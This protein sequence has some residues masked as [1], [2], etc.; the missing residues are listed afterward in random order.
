M[1]LE[2]MIDEYRFTVRPLSAE[3]GG[4]Y[5]IEYPDLPGCVSDGDTAE[6]A[7]RNGRDAALSYLQSC[8]KHGDPV[9]M[10]AS[11]K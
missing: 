6:E 4:G 11:T 7:V 8:V 5:L 3:D 9:P 2:A 10:R 1:N